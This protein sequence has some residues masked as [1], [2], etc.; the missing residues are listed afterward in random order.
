MKE[1]RN[2][3]DGEFFGRNDRQGGFWRGK[4]ER[5]K[6]ERGV[7][8]ARTSSIARGDELSEFEFELELEL[9]GS[10]IFDLHTGVSIRFSRASKI[11]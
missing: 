3:L 8:R 4:G 6:G 10:D 7:P 9:E 1:N 2:G 5:G 11:K